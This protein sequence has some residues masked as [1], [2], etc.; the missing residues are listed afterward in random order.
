[1]GGR[2]GS[3]RVGREKRQHFILAVILYYIHIRSYHWENWVR[4]TLCYILQLLVI[5]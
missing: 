5:L 2:E 3:I 1:M 4:G